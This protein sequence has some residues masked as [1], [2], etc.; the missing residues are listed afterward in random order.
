[1][2]FARHPSH[3]RPVGPEGVNEPTALAAH[4]VLRVGILLAYVTKIVSPIA[5]IPNGAKP[6]GMPGSTNVVA[7]LTTSNVLSNM[8]TLA[9]WKSV[10]YNMLPSGVEAIARPL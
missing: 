7:V 2:L 3:E 10:A 8:S 4:L 5:W 9:L 6:A 1:M